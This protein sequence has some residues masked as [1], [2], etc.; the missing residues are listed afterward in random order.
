[1]IDIDAVYG[2]TPLGQEYPLDDVLC[3]MKRFGISFALTASLKSAYF[4]TPE[5]DAEHLAV[6]RAHDGLLPAASVNLLYGFCAAD[7]VKRLKTLGFRAARFHNDIRGFSPDVPLFRE[8]I[9]AAEDAQL[10]I[11]ISAPAD[12][13]FRALLPMNRLTV[14]II[15][16]DQDP[17]SHYS[18]V[19]AMENR[20]NFYLDICGFNNPGMIDYLAGRVGADHLLFGSGAPKFYTQP[21]LNTVACSRLS[22]EDQ[23][24][25]LDGNARRIFQ[26]ERSEPACR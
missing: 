13:V 17:Y 2:R 11:L 1:M 22:A 23:E 21:T 14:P 26:I 4:F 18:I 12:A 7:E 9:A 8:F 25:I 10:P 24:R 3:Q 19:S 20:D 15:L 5:S 6:C 16:L